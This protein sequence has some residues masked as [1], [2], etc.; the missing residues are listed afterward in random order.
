M[1]QGPLW[2]GFLPT[3]FPEG[4]AIMPQFCDVL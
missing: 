4:K 2:F 1:A 3:L